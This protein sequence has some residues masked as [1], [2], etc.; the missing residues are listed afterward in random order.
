MCGWNV[1]QQTPIISYNNNNNNNNNNAP[2][3][4]LRCA[5]KSHRR[6]TLR[7]SPSEPSA[8]G[9]KKSKAPPPQ[10]SNVPLPCRNRT[11]PNRKHGFPPKLR[12]C[13]APPLCAPPHVSAKAAMRLAFRDC[14]RISGDVI[15]YQNHSPRA[16]ALFPRS[17]CAEQRFPFS[18]IALATSAAFG[19]LRRA[20][21]AAP[22][23]H[24]A[25]TL[26]APT[27]RPLRASEQARGGPFSAAGRAPAF[28][29]SRLISAKIPGT[30]YA[31]NG[32]APQGLAPQGVHRNAWHRNAWHR[33]STRFPV[34]SIPTE[35]NPA[36]AAFCEKAA[37]PQTV[38]TGT[39]SFSPKSVPRPSFSPAAKKAA[40]HAK[41][42]DDAPP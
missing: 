15:P 23:L 7:G 37:A 6:R 1:P 40:P 16:P 8:L 19:S 31:Q 2:H 24:S 35:T 39:R 4:P 12:R 29:L 30:A 13:P 38:S 34:K 3:Q 9:G 42:K 33:K 14:K 25:C 17:A 20:N 36:L 28:A 41:T 32:H 5:A 22:R 27:A 21:N 26:A 10:K 18:D 11:A